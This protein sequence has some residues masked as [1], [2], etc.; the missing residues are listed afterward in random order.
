MPEDQNVVGDYWTDETIALLTKLGWQ[1]RGARNFDIDCSKHKKQRNGQ[2]HG[3]DCLFSYYDPYLNRTNG[4]IVE[5]KSRQWDGLSKS[6][7]ESFI[8]QVMSCLECAQEA[9]QL[10]E[11]GFDAINTAL[12]V[13]WCN[14]GNYNHS[15]YIDR[16]RSLKYPLK[17]REMT[18][19]LASNY[20]I[21]RWCSII[22]TMSSIKN[23]SLE[24]K[25]CYPYIV[26]NNSDLCEDNYLTLFYLYSK[27]IFARNKVRKVL[28]DTTKVI[29]QSIVFYFDEVSLSGLQFM[30]DAFRQYQLQ[31]A[32]EFIIYL[33]INRSEHREC[34]DEFKRTINEQ[35]TK[36]GSHKSLVVRYMTV[37]TGTETVPYNI[38]GI[39]EE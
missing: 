35:L 19:Y 29:E 34:V 21:L 11:F 39:N 8:T 23:N 37:L 5:S 20:D 12:I 36:N 38:L 1:Q 25:F 14:D 2:G 10:Q 15:Q 27:Y 24:F 17:L 6:K 3:I 9:S 7:L 28:G 22:D 26:N 18:I 33:Y 16:L 13:C 32:D 31:R 30:Y 4:I